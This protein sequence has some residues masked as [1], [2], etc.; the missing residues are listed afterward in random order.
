MLSSSKLAYILCWVRVQTRNRAKCCVAAKIR[1]EPPMFAYSPFANGGCPRHPTFQRL[2]AGYVAT[3]TYIYTHLCLSISLYTSM[4]IH[5]R[6]YMYIYVYTYIHICN[7]T[8]R[9]TYL[10]VWYDRVINFAFRLLLSDFCLSLMLAAES[11]RIPHP[12][13]PLSKIMFFATAP[14]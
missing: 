8:L 4:H 12:P 9:T 3:C 2:S 7:R 14:C 1:L 13:E 5:I 11:V 10:F 6:I